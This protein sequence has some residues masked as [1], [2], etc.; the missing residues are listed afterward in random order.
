[1]YGGCHLEEA[2]RQSWATPLLWRVFKLFRSNNPS[3]LALLTMADGEKYLE[4]KTSG[5]P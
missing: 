1:M 4:G 3:L 5:R 2:L